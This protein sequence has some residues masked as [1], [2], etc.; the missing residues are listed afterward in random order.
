MESALIFKMNE[1]PK[2]DRG[3]GVVTTP[4]VVHQ[5]APEA[6]FSSGFTSFPPGAGATMHSH[7]CGEHVLIL[8]GE[9]EVEVDGKITRLGKYDSA[10]VEANK[11]HCYRNIG[12]TPLVILWIYGSDHVTRT[13]ASTGVMVEHLTPSDSY[14]R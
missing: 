8:E 14:S 4:L 7:N 10:Y 11:R 2:L 6:A 3:A 13:F 12:A 5:R 9:S 1:V